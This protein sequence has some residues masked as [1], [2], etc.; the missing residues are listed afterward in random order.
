MNFKIFKECITKMGIEIHR[1]DPTDPECLGH[2]Y[3]SKANEANIVDYIGNV[4]TTGGKRGGN[5]Y[6]GKATEW[7]N[8]HPIEPVVERAI[9]TIL[10]EYWPDIEYLTYKTVILPMM[11]T[12]SYYENEYYGNS[13]DYILTYVVLEDLFVLLAERGKF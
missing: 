9:D 3:G 1:V 12:T 6:S 10:M 2:S 4:H 7:V 13:T 5:C 11:R 8:F